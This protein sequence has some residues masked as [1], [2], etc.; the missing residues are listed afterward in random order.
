MSKIIATA[1]IKGAHKIVGQA[2]EAYQKVL[3]EHGPDKKIEFPNTGYYLPVIYAMTGIKVEKI[4]DIKTVL[5]EADRLLPPVPAEKVWLPY[6]GHT[7]D[8]GMATLYADEIIEVL[9]YLQNPIPYTMEVNVNGSGLWLGAANDIIMR[10]RGIEFVDGS[11]PGF[12]ACVGAAPDSK[13][14]AKLAQELQ[15][16][17]LYVFMSC[18]TDGNSMAE[19]LKEEGVQMGWDTRL[20]PFGKDVTATV[21]ALGFACRAAMAFGGVQ[22]GDFRRNLMYNKNRIFAFVLALGKVSQ[23]KYAQ[24]AG[25]INFGFP[26]IADT[27]I[28]QILPTGICTY[29]HVVSEIPHS[30]M[31]QKAIEV[32]GLKIKITKVPVP[33]PYGPAFEGERIRRE[34]MYIE[35][36]GDK[37]PAFEWL[38]MKESNEV[39]DGKVEIIGQDIDKLEIEPSKTVIPLGVVAEVAGRKMESDFEPIIERQFHTMINEASGLFHMGQRDLIRVRISKVAFE[40]GL[41]LEHIGKILHAK[42]HD[43]FG[44]I[45]D[46][47]QVKIITDENEIE[48]WRQKA[49]DVFH[50][51]DDRIKDLTDEKVDMFYSC[52]LCQ[53]FA[54]THVCVITPQRPGLCGAFNWLDGKAAF[55]IDPS[56]GHQPI[57]KKTVVD[58]TVGQWQEANDYVKEVSRGKIERM[59]AYSMIV[60]PMTSCGCFECIACILPMT[61]GIMVADREFPEMTPCG[62]KFSTLAGT[63]GGGAQTPGFVGH[64]RLYIISEKFISAD[65][66]LKRLVWMPKS[67][68]ET[69]KDQLNER[70]KAIGVP[71]LIDKIADETVATTEE[72]VLQYITEKGHPVLTMDPML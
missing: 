68:K 50:Y 20:V 61:N 31:V 18:D 9:K 30:E 39:E 26:V 23:E 3:A 1:A 4:G 19:Q 33:V 10:E 21:F 45:V 48:S 15:E 28:P 64:S 34:D 66:G 27:D 46:K 40:K 41:R 55:E 22:P 52:T 17:N 58:E 16:K 2:E 38:T 35:A 71:D 11:A 7:L 53:S 5:K 24:A 32:R 69:L 51:R 62:M 8:A 67:L 25:A 43:E 49:R 70:A 42:I 63:V 12:A 59:S 57:P 37:K 14:A 54:P 65:G 36:T 29:E 56:G 72:E 47:V 6:L 13:T 60:D 44:A